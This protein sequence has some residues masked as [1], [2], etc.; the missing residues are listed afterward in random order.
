V[1]GDGAT[2]DAALEALLAFD[3]L[4]IPANMLKIHAISAALKR[5]DANGDGLPANVVAAS[6]AAV[7]DTG[8]E[9]SDDAKSGSVGDGAE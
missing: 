4:G 9:S 2:D 6:P 3:I 8:D 7:S 5:W 1:A